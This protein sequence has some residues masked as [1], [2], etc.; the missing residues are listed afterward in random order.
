MNGKSTGLQ[1][2]RLCGP[3][4]NGDMGFRRIMDFNE[5]MLAKQGWR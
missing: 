5:A 3:K 1:G 2:N 4:V